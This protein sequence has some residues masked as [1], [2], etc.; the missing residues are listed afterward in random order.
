MS[1]TT[2]APTENTPENT[3]APEA[4]YDESLVPEAQRILVSAARAE[5]SATAKEA[6]ALFS[7]VQAHENVAATIAEVRKESDDEI[8]VKFREWL[9]KAN[10]AIIAEEAKIDEYIKSNLI[11]KGED[12][13]VDAVKAAHKEL[14]K[15]VRGLRDVLVMVGGGENATLSLPGVKS[16]SGRAVSGGGTG[17]RRHRLDNVTVDGKDV[18]AVKR[19]KEA[20]TEEH[21][22]SFGALHAFLNKHPEVKGTGTSVELTDLHNA[23]YKAAGTDDFASLNGKPFKFSVTASGKNE[24]GTMKYGKTFAEIVLTPRVG[25]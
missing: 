22:A 8:V 18:Y 12:F 2:T 9:E 1:E 21:I 4:Q 13:D 10:N 7:K 14:V 17:I 20:G 5:Y 25:K 15:K 19:D 23:A 16:I 11:P 6:N 24:D 3:E